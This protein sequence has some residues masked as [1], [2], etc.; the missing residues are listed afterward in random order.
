[1]GAENLRKAMTILFSDIKGSTQFAEKRG[2][3]EYMAMI[4]RH[5]RILF[6]VIEAE[7]G[8]IVKTIG[9]A[10]LAKFDDP[11][12]AVK[13]A[14]EMQRALAK[15]GEG[16]EAIDQICIRIGLHQ[17]MGLVKDNDVFG[18][19]VNAASHVEH[20]AQAGQVLITDTLLDATKS[21]GLQ[22]AKMGRADL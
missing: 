2:D 12:S 14:A 3:V 10:I 1:M 21:A 7:G 15:D 18:D 9:D 4:D 19:V 22:C 13:A 20:Q 11:A 8:L 5:N 6:P 16:R 17:G